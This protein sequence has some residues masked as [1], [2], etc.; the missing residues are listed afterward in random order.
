MDD[1]HDNPTL[2]IDDQGYIW[3]YVAGR[4]NGRPGHRYRS[5]SPYDISKFELMNSSIM[6]YPQPIYIKGKGHFLFF[7]RY[8]GRRQL[9]FRRVQM[10]KLGVIINK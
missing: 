8:D 1:P 10:E 7:T 4:G 2:V 3:V 9:F 6:A 5:A